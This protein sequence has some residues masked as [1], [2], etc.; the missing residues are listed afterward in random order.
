MIGVS[1]WPCL[2]IKTNVARLRP[3]CSVLQSN[4]SF[5]SRPYV[6]VLPPTKHCHPTTYCHRARPLFNVSEIKLDLAGMNVTTASSRDPGLIN[7]SDS[8]FTMFNAMCVIDLFQLHKLLLANFPA[9][10]V[11]SGNATRQPIA[12]APDQNLTYGC[13][14]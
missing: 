3:R 2:L 9:Q 13:M 1:G 14:S 10:R 7:L 6:Y 11:N 8:A 4:L 12:H 5:V